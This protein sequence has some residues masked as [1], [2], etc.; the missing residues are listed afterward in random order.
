LPKGAAK[1]LV[2]QRSIDGV[3]RHGLGKRH[4]R[5]SNYM[6]DHGTVQDA[7]ILCHS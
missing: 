3:G 7:A 5:L 6:F 1:D 4:S 2:H